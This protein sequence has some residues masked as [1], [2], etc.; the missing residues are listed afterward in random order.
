MDGPG[1]R[2]RFVESP[3]C[4][5]SSDRPFATSGALFEQQQMLN[6]ALLPAWDPWYVAFEKAARAGAAAHVRGCFSG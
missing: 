6:G 5:A 4:G 3:W 2:R 1:A